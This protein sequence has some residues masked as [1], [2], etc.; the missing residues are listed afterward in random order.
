MMYGVSGR[1]TR[2][3]DVVV[4]KVRIEEVGVEEAGVSHS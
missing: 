2:V 4:E 3:K 1:R